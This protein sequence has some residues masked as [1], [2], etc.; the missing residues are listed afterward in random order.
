MEFWNR[1]CDS[2]IRIKQYGPRVKGDKVKPFTEDCNFSFVL[3]T[4]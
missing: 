3:K 1:L 4:L 2:E